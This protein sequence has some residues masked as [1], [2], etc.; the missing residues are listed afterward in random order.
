MKEPE[1]MDDLVYFTKRAIEP[2]GHAKAWV[3][4]VM[5]PA[6]GKAKMSKPELKGKVQIRAKEYV[7]PECGYREDKKAHEDKLTVEIIYTCPFCQDKGEAT[8]EYKR[9]SFNGVPS[10]VFACQKCGKKIGITKK[11]K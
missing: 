9:K 7:C 3:H 10:Y 8:T 6:C 5:C 4:K 2:N 1:S 11:M